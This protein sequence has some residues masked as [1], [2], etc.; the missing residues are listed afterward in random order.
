MLLHLA[1]IASAAVGPVHHD[2]PGPLFGFN[3]AAFFLA[4]ATI[5][6]ARRHQRNRRPP[7]P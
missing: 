5:A 3:A 7:Q 2:A 1:L 4:I 6:A